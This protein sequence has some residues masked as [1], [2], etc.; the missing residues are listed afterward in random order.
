MS[1]WTTR[2]VFHA[3]GNTGR[4]PNVLGLLIPE[5][6]KT[7]LMT[8][9]QE[10]KKGAHKRKA[11]D[12]VDLA[13][14]RIFGYSW[15]TSFQ[16]DE[17]KLSSP[18]TRQLVDIFGLTTTARILDSRGSIKRRRVQPD[19]SKK[20]LDYKNI[21]LPQ[22][23]SPKVMETA[24]FAGQ[25]IQREKKDIAPSSKSG[26]AGNIDNVL[27]KLNGPDKINTVQKTN[28][29]WET[30][31]SENKD[32]QDDL[33]KK[34]QSKDAYLVKQDFLNRVDQRKFELEKEKRDRERAQRATS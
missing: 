9:Q 34:A 33:E 32:L 26:A 21:V 10:D 22:T 24:V 23:V 6:H 11:G 13:F 3:S 14:E 2:C 25:A 4:L 1:Q 28:N 29:D 17:D 8:V 31:K 30:W 18:T 27:A 7:T 16:L 19:E 12:A 15:G 5:R 20:V